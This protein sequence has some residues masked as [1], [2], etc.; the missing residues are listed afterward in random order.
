MKLLLNLRG[1]LRTVIH[2][3]FLLFVIF[4][5]IVASLLTF[6][7]RHGI[8]AYTRAIIVYLIIGKLLITKNCFKTKG[9][10]FVYALI[11]YFLVLTLFSSDFSR[12]IS[13][14]SK[15]VASLMLLPISV[16]YMKNTGDL[17]KFLSFCK[18]AFVYFI[19]FA[20]IS[21]VFNIGWN[22]YARDKETTI[23]LGF[24]DSQLYTFSLAL[25]AVPFYKKYSGDKFG[26]FS[27]L[28]MFLSFLLLVFSMRRTSVAIVLLGYFFYFFFSGGLSRF[29]RL[30][31]IG[32]FVLIISFPLYQNMLLERISLRENVMNKEYSLEEEYRWKETIFLLDDVNRYDQWSTIIF[33]K[34]IFNSPG[35]YAQ[36]R[37]GGRMLHVDFNRILHGSGILGLSM[38]LLIYI[39]ILQ[40]F[41]FYYKRSRLENKKELKALF[42][43]YYF[44]SL[45]ISFSGQMDDMTF[46]S[47]LFIIMGAGIGILK[48]NVVNAGRNVYSCISHI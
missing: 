29:V 6:F 34:E 7:E 23:A 10:N 32:A 46:R 48:N 33:G 1:Y 41:L 13:L 2:N 27:Y 30:F 31:F 47:V 39:L 9:L 8:L 17:I 12:S 16:S 25:V 4:N 26:I 5:I 42:L 35:N 37:L 43:T 45:F 38:Y 36:G 14:F 20:I 24:G 18:F 19:S 44:L 22:Q 3:K 21:S 28:L 40:T 11:L 15:V